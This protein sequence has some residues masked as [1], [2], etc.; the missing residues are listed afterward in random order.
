[1][2]HREI[3]IANLAGNIRRDKL[4][5]RDCLVVPVRMLKPTVL[6][7]SAGPVYY[8]AEQNRESVKRWNGMP[9]VLNHP[10]RAGRP[11][12]ARTSEVLNQTGIGVVLNTSESGGQLKAEAW[13]DIEN[14]NKIDPRIVQKLEAGQAVEVSTGLNVKAIKAEDGANVGG[15]VYNY[16]ATEYEPDHLAVLLDE[17]GACSI[18]DGCGMLVNRKYV[19]PESKELVTNAMSHDQLRHELNMALRKQ[20][21]QDE[22]EAWIDD[23]FDGFFVYRQNGEL[24]QQTYSK[25][26]NG[27]SLTGTPVKVMRDEDFVPV[28]NVD[29]DSSPETDQ[30]TTAPKGENSMSTSVMNADQRKDIVNKLVGNCNCYSEEDRT[31]L[32]SLSDKG[33]TR[34]A[35]TLLNSDTSKGQGQGKETASQTTVVNVETPEK[36][37]AQETGQQGDGKIE[38]TVINSDLKPQTT[39]EWLAQQPPQ[40]QSVF[41]NALAVEQQ[42]RQDIVNLLTSTISDD[43]AK[44]TAVEVYNTIKIEDLRKLKAVAPKPVTKPQRDYSAQSVTTGIANLKTNATCYDDLPIPPGLFEPISD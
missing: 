42:E 31:A 24:Y 5:G 40:V 14:A 15:I 29:Q 38:T 21:T 9:I 32:N 1:M 30:G 6:N 19:D 27:V 36:P 11:V 12:S 43:T 7:G 26:D 2:L 20:F 37:K 10:F 8:P 16:I 22:P 44:A 34:L 13:I 33:L 3:I 28:S 35:E 18:Q 41:N 4:Q 17:K 25:S 23:V 39:E